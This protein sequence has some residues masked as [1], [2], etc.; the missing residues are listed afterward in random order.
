VG[1]WI[2]QSDEIVKDHTCCG[3]FSACLW[4]LNNIFNLPEEKSLPGDD[5][6][7]P[8]YIVG[9]NAF[10]INKRLMNPF[11]IRN[12]ENHER[13]DT[14]IVA[15]TTRADI[16]P[17][18]LVVCVDQGHEYNGE[19]ALVVSVHR[20]SILRTGDRYMVA[21]QSTTTVW[22]LPSL[23]NNLPEEKSLPGDDV[24]VPYYIV[25]DNAFGINKR[26]MNLFVI[27]NM[28][29]HERILNY[30][31]SRAR[32]VVE[33]AFGILAHKFRVLLRTMN[34]RPETCRK[35]ITTCVILHNLIWD[36]NVITR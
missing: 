29:H 33:N 17:E 19:E 36:R 21:I 2:S 20:A 25:G 9:D 6:P 32:R 35:I 26:L 22:K 13:I 34:Q 3:D 4:P 31:L 5:V 12:M 28:E 1:G 8:Y 16:N 11:A 14:G 7:V 10:G 15:G 27:R 30:R 18:K 23:L 24:P